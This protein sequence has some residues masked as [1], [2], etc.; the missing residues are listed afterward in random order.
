MIRRDF[1]FTH[2]RQKLNTMVRQ[3]TPW[4]TSN[5]E[6]GR[7]L[8]AQAALKRN[9]VT[10]IT[11]KVS[12]KVSTPVSR[13]K[14]LPQSAIIA[15]PDGRRSI[16]LPPLEHLSYM[17]ARDKPDITT[18]QLYVNRGMPPPKTGLGKRFMREEMGRFWQN[19]QDVSTDG[20]MPSAVHADV[21]SII[22]DSKLL[23]PETRPNTNQTRPNTNQTRP[24][25]NQTRP[26]TNQTRPNTNQ[27]RLNTNQTRPTTNQ[28][29]TQSRPTTQVT[30]PTT[31]VSQSIPENNILTIENND[32]VQTTVNNDM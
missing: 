12:S 24:N 28:T 5:A 31:N 22:H 21:L 16:T 30:R 19:I 13:Q 8:A 23:S 6:Y 18:T 11:S 20:R 26:N 7:H 9:S 27:T 1:V 32:P 14:S 3:N 25:T 2:A 17:P 10:S 29:F 15:P 4:G